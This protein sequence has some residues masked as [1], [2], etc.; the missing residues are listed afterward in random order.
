MSNR[1]VFIEQPGQ[2]GEEV[3]V[4][5][6]MWRGTLWDVKQVG[7]LQVQNKH[8]AVCQVMC[9]IS[10]VYHGRSDAKRSY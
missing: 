7:K 6:L 3:E 4:G 9:V 10:H 2:S 5:L 8:G 1:I